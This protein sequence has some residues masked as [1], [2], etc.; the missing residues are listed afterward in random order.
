MFS[1]NSD[2]KIRAA[3]ESMPSILA[4]GLVIT[5]NLECDGEL[6][7]DGIV[8]GNIRADRLTLG[9]T[10]HVTGDI[11]VNVLHIHGKVDG[12]ITAVEVIIADT[13]RVK[14]DVT[15]SSLKIESGAIVDGHC[16]HS[17]NPRGGAETVALFNK[18]DAAT[19]D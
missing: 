15:N 5:G 17:D 8:V 4:K 10:S 1:G 12:N 18:E 9:E 3:D 7:V 6:Q 13:G 2:K 16:Q 11:D 19:S 14:G